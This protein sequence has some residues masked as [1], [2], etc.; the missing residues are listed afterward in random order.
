[1]GARVQIGA[2]QAS[3]PADRLVRRRR[4]AGAGPADLP[5]PRRRPGLMPTGKAS[6]II[7]CRRPRPSSSC[8]PTPTISGRGSAPF[9]GGVHLAFIFRTGSRDDQDPARPSLLAVAGA[10]TAAAAG[11]DP[12]DFE[13]RPS[14]STTPAPAS[15]ISS[16]RRRRA[17]AGIST[18]SRALVRSARRTCGRTPSAPRARPP[19]QR[20]SLRRRRAQRA[21]LGP[22]DGPPRR[23]RLLDRVTRRRGLAE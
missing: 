11:A 17:G 13:A 5:G 4:L 7:S 3:R 19:D 15:S 6:T 22:P 1:M 21:Q 16:S 12:P 2:S 20:I 10:A 14:G 18:R 23:R 9:P 8:K